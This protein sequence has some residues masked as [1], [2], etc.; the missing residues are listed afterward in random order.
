LLA[1]RIKE[2][3]VVAGEESSAR[4]ASPVPAVVLRLVERFGLVIVFLGV[5]VAF[6]S[7]PKTGSIFLTKA[8]LSVV[9]GSQSVLAIIAIGAMIPLIA[10]EF[11]LSVGS[12]AGLCSVFSAAYL[13]H[14]GANVSVGIAMA[15]GLGALVGLVN[16]IIVVHLKVTSLIATLGTST[17]ISGIVLQYTSGLSII[18]VPKSLTDFG[19]GDSLGLPNT[20]WV[21][22]V[23][24]VVTIYLLEYTPF[25]RYLHSIGSN[26]RASI[27]VGISVPRLVLLTYVVSGV[28]AGAAGALLVAR[29]GGANPQTGFDYTLPALAA[30]FLG[31]TTI[32]P[33]RFNTIGTFV[34]VFFL[35]ALSSGL[36]L[37]G[38]PSY[39]I[40]YING[41]ALVV[42]VAISSLLSARRRKGAI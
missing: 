17:I 16:G 34:A 42:G 7:I 29:L 10:G 33:G 19:D 30:V 20:L 15:I 3:E 32:R 38:A 1:D 12:N 8:N 24:G 27:L 37:Y 26:R 6:G 36:N 40:D 39:A 31:A 23:V 25:G 18:N 21:V 5:V 2:H 4:T 22:L 41:G 9:V 11:D 28:F 14:H 35:A 13:A